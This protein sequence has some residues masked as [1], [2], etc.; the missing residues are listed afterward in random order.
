[1]VTFYV[2]RH[3]QNQDNANGIL[4][5]HRDLPLTA[6]G[7]EQAGIL[8]NQIKEKNLKFDAVYTSPLQRASKTAEIVCGIIEHTTPPI[9]E[10]DLIERDFG[11][12]SGKRTSDI[13]SFCSPDTIVKTETITYFLEPANGENFPTLIARA[14]RLLA[15]LSTTD[16]QKA[17]QKV[18]L[19]CHGDFGKM[20]YASFYQE[21][22]KDVL[23]SFHFGNSDVLILS[24]ELRTADSSS[25]K[26]FTQQQ[27]N[28]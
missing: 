9:I 8:G 14:D 28:N 2:A 6:I 11:I 22:W 21:E 3:G 5:G 10:A 12:M 7:E 4:N 25:R 20:I 23:F 26:L 24:D 13:E 27:Y 19:V 18:L 1:M 15:K 17:D 16:Q